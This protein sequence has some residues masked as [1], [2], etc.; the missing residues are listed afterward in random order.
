MIRP[1]K[2]EHLSL[3]TLSSQVLK[4]EGKGKQTQLKDLSDVSFLG[5]LLVFPANGRLDCKVIIYLASSK[6]KSVV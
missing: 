6:G 4:F 5:K 2:L 1:S 3:E